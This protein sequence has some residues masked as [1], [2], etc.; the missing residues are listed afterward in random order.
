MATR[1]LRLTIDVVVDDDGVPRGR[2]GCATHPSFDF[3]G[4]LGL[5]SGLDRHL[6]GPGPESDLSAT[7]ERT[8]ADAGS[9]PARGRRARGIEAGGSD[10][11]TP[12]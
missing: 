9:T 5:L 12:P 2:I 8:D 6:T 4:W 3:T 7:V 11:N 10:A 1:R